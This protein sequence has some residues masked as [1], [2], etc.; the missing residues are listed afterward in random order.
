MPL[1]VPQYTFFEQSRE[2]K[3]DIMFG[4]TRSVWEGG[5]KLSVSLANVKRPGRASYW[6]RTS[7]SAFLRGD[8]EY[9]AS[10]KV[11]SSCFSPRVMVELYSHDK[12][13]LLALP[14][15]GHPLKVRMRL[16]FVDCFLTVDND[17]IPI[18]SLLFTQQARERGRVRTAEDELEIDEVRRPV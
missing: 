2:E 15:L 7:S 4:M 18:F 12:L 13:W 9:Q 11:S 17:D 1:E 6:Q 16:A 3:A 5:S 10:R 14:L 8:R